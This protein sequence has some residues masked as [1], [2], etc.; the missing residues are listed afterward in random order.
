MTSRRNPHALSAHFNIDPAYSAVKQIP[1]AGGLSLFSERKS[2]PFWIY[3]F[4]DIATHLFNRM[5][6]E[7]FS[8]CKNVFHPGE[9]RN[10]RPTMY[11]RRTFNVRELPDRAVI[12]LFCSGHAMLKVNG[13]SFFSHVFPE[14]PE[15]CEIDILPYLKIGDNEMR[16]TV[17]SL[18][19]PAAFLIQGDIVETDSKWEASSDA[20]NWFAPELVPLEGLSCFPHWEDL[21]EIMLKAKHVGDGVYDFG[22]ET[23]GRPI[24][25]A[26]GQGELTMNV[27][28]SV[29]EART[30]EFTA[31]EQ[32]IP[33]LSISDGKHECEVD[34]SLRY[35]H[36]A[37]PPTVQVGEVM[38]SAPLYP[39]RYKGAFACSDE[40]LT[41]I[42]M[43][44]AYTLKLCMR[45]L[46]V[47]GLKRDRLPW[48]G[49]LYMS[50]L[51][52]SYSFHDRGLMQRSLLAL[53]GDGP[54]TLDVNNIVD[55]SLFWIMALR[56]NLMYFGDIAFLKRAQPLLERLLNALDART[57][58]TGFIPTRK[59]EWVFIDWSEVEKSGY[60]SFIQMLHVIAL[61]AAADI[62]SALGDAGAAADVRKKARKL[63]LKC[64]RTFWSE[65][66][67]AYVDN[68]SDG[69]QGAKISRPANIFAILSGTAG[70]RRMQ[71]VLKNVLLNS[72]VKPVGTPY[73]RTFEALALSRC[74]RMG[75][76]IS[77]L[78]E[79]WGGMVQTGATTFWEG[80]DKTSSG[81]EHY[82]FYGR[83]FGKSL[84]HAWSAGPVYLLSNA[85]TGARPFAPGWSSFTIAPDTAGLKWAAVSIPCPQGEILIDMEGKSVSVTVPEG[86]LFVE[87]AGKSGQRGHQGPCVVELKAGG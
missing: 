31:Q 83:P 19:G 64:D 26:K 8:V 28:E 25:F 80:Y 44:A 16:L 41:D 57:D 74:G 62:C 21:P 56:D 48:G 2:G 6:Q 73:M 40:S 12:S 4:G 69:R 58:S 78:R 49:D 55:Y 54:E 37:H 30:A 71:N 84:C 7:A 61:D 38:L 46:C 79:E 35:V 17:L 13:N 53:Y 34:L 18:G 65:E 10:F 11:A 63:R 22:T 20:V 52:N 14:K 32:L 5:R 3:L 43:R 51:V 85:L 60:S 36:L 68:V 50:G 15:V 47:D 66:H 87:N 27:G 42:W 67:S 59:G 45:W 86:A 1:D 75:E 70:K 33:P 24:I 29:P 77:L 82:A 76:M 72:D 23:F 9:F 39:A 81:L